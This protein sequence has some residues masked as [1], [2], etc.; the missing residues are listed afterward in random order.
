LQKHCDHISE[1]K[2]TALKRTQKENKVHK[3]LDK[4]IYTEEARSLTHLL[5]KAG[6]SPEYV[7][8]VIETVC[9]SAG[10]EVVGKMSRHCWPSYHKG[11]SCSKNAIGVCTKENK[12]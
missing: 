7:G 2:K 5:T 9:K 3:L 1:V 10:V 11:W 8:S 12:G 6:C 4:G